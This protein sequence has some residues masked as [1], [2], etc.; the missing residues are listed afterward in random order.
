MSKTR[1]LSLTE[2]IY[3]SLAVKPSDVEPLVK[4]LEMDRSARYGGSHHRLP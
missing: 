2:V 1:K 4:Y 3:R